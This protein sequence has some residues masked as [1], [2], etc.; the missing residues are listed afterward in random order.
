[1]KKIPLPQRKTTSQGFTLIELLVVIAIIAI[2]AAILFP[3]FGRAR[4]N[5]RRASCQS[6]L[7]QIGLGF[8]QYAQDFDSSYPLEGPQASIFPMPP[9][10]FPGAS[11]AQLNSWGQNWIKSTNPYVKSYQ[12]MQCPSGIEYSPLTA[13]SSAPN[14]FSYSMNA[15]LARTKIGAI[16]R[17]S[18]TVMAWEGTGKYALKGATFSNPSVLSGTLPYAASTAGVTH[19]FGMYT[20]FGAPSTGGWN[21]HLDGSNFL[22]TDGHVKWVKTPSGARNGGAWSA[23]NAQGEATGNY[24]IVN[25]TTD[26]NTPPFNFSPALADRT[27]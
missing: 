23:V 4:E 19:T 15:L 20:G 17:P 13:T 11:A 3:V 9:E 1:M 22:Y 18:K 10:A 24:W 21:H 16:G 5:A 25:S 27:D 26:A 14:S 2:L 12:V 8:T 6:N 7:K